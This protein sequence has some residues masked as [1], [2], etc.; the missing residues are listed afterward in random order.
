MPNYDRTGPDGKGPLTGRGKGPCKKDQ[1]N[2]KR[3]RRGF[4]GQGR[5]RGR[6]RRRG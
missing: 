5:G 3:P 1:P 6:N 4:F 2:V